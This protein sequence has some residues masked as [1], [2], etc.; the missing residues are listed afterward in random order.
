MKIEKK[1]QKRGE[2][3]RFRVRNHIQR[4]AHGRPRLSVFRSNR[5]MYAQ[6]I[7]DARGHTLVAASTL[8]KGVSGPGSTA[9]D[10]ESAVK[11]GKL[12]A[13][14][15]LE[16]GIKQVVLDRGGYQYH[17]RVAALATAARETGL[18]F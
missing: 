10:K 1:L 6:I 15:A 2:R 3:R 8:E 16:Q 13:E 4:A 14:R 18:E 9:G 5:H 7:D 11:V 17:G 12:L